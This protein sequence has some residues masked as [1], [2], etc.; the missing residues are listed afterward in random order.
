MAIEN[1]LVHPGIFLIVISFLYDVFPKSFRKIIAISA[2]IFAYILLYIRMNFGAADILFHYQQNLFSFTTFF[3]IVLLA[4]ILFALSNSKDKNNDIKFALLYAGS[5]ISAL[6]TDNLLVVFIFL[7]IMLVAA[8]FLIFNGNNKLSK[9]IGIAYFK[10]HAA[11]GILFLIGLIIHY[12]EYKNLNISRYDLHD[13]SS[14]KLSVLHFSMLF[15]LL[16]NIAVPPFSY[17]LTEGY[18]SSSPVGSVFLSVYTT[19][20]AIFLIAKMFIGNKDLI[21]VGIF[22]SFYGIIYAILENNLRKIISFNII[23]QLGLI[24]IAIAIGDNASKDSAMLMS[25]NGI[26][27]IAL[28]MMCAGS[29]IIL[30][31]KEHYYN[32]NYIAKKMKFVFICSLIGFASI[33]TL[34]FTAGY[35]GKYFLYQSDYVMANKWLQYTI[36]A[37]SSGMMFA[38]GIKFPAFVFLANFKQ[39]EKNAKAAT[40]YDLPIYGMLALFLLTFCCLVIGIFP[41][42]ILRANIS[43]FSTLSFDYLLLFLGTLVGFV[44]LQRLI[45]RF[46]NAILL[47]FDWVYRHFL[48]RIYKFGCKIVLLLNNL[49]LRYRDKIAEFFSNSMNILFGSNGYLTYFKSQK[50]FVIVTIILLIILLLHV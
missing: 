35:V 49:W 36:T 2:P 8:S 30:L 32:I 26:M 41:K 20:V 19:K 40:N 44:M 29:I 45:L 46:D 21:F 12:L 27:Y 10:I 42:T 25:I 50:N 17:W 1:I 15:A 23:S 7:E 48:Y 3:L 38:V 24:L 4:G 6:L 14:I 47:D 39:K 31:N 33:S 22:M 43:F 34:P 13:F 5:S 16:I 37:I 9:T 11:A 28:V 18:S